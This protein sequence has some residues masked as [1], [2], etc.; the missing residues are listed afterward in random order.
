MN[1]AIKEYLDS[2]AGQLGGAASQALKQA[3]EKGRQQG[4]VDAR[5]ELR[6]KVVAALDDTPVVKPVPQNRVRGVANKEKPERAVSGTVRPAI[7]TV[8]QAAVSGLRS[9]QVFD[10]VQK[11]GHLAI[12]DNTVRATLNKFKEEGL[13]E[14]RGDLWFWVNK[15][16]ALGGTASDSE[17]GGTM[18]SS[19]PNS[20]GEG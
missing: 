4:L 2:L 5:D 14:K 9:N 1:D 17:G 10:A 11:G 3:Y 18:P 7:I 15:N 12:K 13:T 16:K 8:M 6:A 20:Q 19:P